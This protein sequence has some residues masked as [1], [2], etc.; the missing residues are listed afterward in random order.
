MSN[1]IAFERLGIGPLDVNKVA[2]SVGGFNIYWYAIIITAGLALAVLFCSRFV[3]RYGMKSDDVIDIVLWCGPFALIG[4]RL[5]YIL[6]SIQDFLTDGRLDIGKVIDVRSGG[7][8]IYGGVIVGFV[9]AYFVCR[10]K[11]IDTMAMFDAGAIGFLIG[12]CIGRWGNFVNAEAYGTHTDLPWGMSINGGAAVHPTFLYES[13]WNLLGFILIYTFARTL[14]RR[15]GE[16]FF[17][18]IGWYGL[19]RVWIEGLRTDSLYLFTDSFAQSHGLYNPRISQ[20]IAALSII[21]GIIGYILA[22]KGVFER[23]HRK[24][25]EKYLQWLSAHPEKKPRGNVQIAYTDQFQE[26]ESEDGADTER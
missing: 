4:A 7:L 2:F 10:Y 15:S 22:R 19:G 23:A 26:E 16:L 20:I 3:K 8:A 9:T 21:A 11:K 25:M 13:L 18:Y 17:M 14:A 1:K 12:Q 6:F 5:Y 24:N